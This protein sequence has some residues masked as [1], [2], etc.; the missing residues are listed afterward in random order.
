MVGSTSELGLRDFALVAKYG[1]QAKLEIYPL[2][3][4]WRIF[5]I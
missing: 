4:S 1:Q 5:Q 2:A 3:A